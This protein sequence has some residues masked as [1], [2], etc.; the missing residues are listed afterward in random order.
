MRWQIIKDG[1][2]RCADISEREACINH[3]V[4][5]QTVSFTDANKSITL[6]IRARWV[7]RWAVSVTKHSNARDL[8]GRVTRRWLERIELQKRLPGE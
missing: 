4:W 1:E 7:E 2:S 5:R 3:R 8:D 6:A